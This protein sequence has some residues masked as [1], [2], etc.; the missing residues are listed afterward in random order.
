MEEM[1]KKNI[2]EWFKVCCIDFWAEK[3]TRKK[4][5]EA[6]EDFLHALREDGEKVPEYKLT[7]AEIE[8][9]MKI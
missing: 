9:L 3:K 1:T 2:Y 6:W 5:K 4:V 7:K 8:D